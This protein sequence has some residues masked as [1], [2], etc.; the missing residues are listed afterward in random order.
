L[1]SVLQSLTVD[2]SLS[3]LSSLARRSPFDFHRRF[4]S[5]TG[6]T[7]KQYTLRLRLERAA[8][9]LALSG[10]SI[11]TVALDNGFGGIEVFSRAF[12]RHFGQP[13]S[14]Y[15]TGVRRLVPRGLWRRHAALTASVGPC[16]RLFGPAAVSTAGAPMPTLSIVREVREPRPMLFVRRRVARSEIA[17]ALAECFGKT[18]GHCQQEGL[19][20][21]GRP[22]ARYYVTGPGLLTIEAGVPLAIAAPACGDIEA[23]ELPGGPVAVAVHAGPYDDLPATHAAVERWLEARGLRSS[24]APWES[25]ITDPAEHPDPADWRTEVCWPLVS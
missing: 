19:P 8:V 15:R 10:A 25:Y 6:E 12:R 5:L 23:G 17:T 22:T 1:R 20:M 11:A 21:A 2:T 14:R 16:V 13:P 3:Q 24:G 4:R 9:Q 18:Y 7:P